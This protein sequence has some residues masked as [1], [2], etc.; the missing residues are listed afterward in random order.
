MRLLPNTV[1]ELIEE[2]DRDYPEQCP[3]PNW[4]ERE[5]WIKAG[6]RQVVRTLRRRQQFTKEHKLDTR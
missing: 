6:Q 5:V 1:D 3:S 4:G 2:L